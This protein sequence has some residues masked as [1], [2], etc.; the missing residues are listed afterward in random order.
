MLIKKTIYPRVHNNSQQFSLIPA[1]AAQNSTGVPLIRNDDALGDP[2][3]LPT[4][5]EHASFAE[6]NSSG[7]YPDSRINKIFAQIQFNMSTETVATDALTNI[8]V[9]VIPVFMAFKEDYTAIDEKSQLEIQDVLH[10][11]TEATDRQGGFLWVATN[12]TNGDDLTLPTDEPFM[13]TNTVYENVEW[14]LEPIYDM[15]HYQ[16]NGPK[17]SA[18]MGKIRHITLSTKHPTTYRLS[19]NVNPKVKRINP[20]TFCGILVKVPEDGTI[21]QNWQAT[22]FTVASYVRCV[23]QYRYNEW[24]DDFESSKV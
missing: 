22:E 4:N 20:Y 19:V 24:N 14:Q 7:C 12:L 21:H 23:S 16:T 13:D 11:Q 15:L 6:T 3:S 8:K 18:V 17:L 2:K 5:P 9:V 10:L 1:T